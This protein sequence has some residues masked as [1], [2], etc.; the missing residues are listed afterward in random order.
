MGT[1][2]TLLVS[3]PTCR[4]RGIVLDANGDAQKCPRCGGLG[5]API[6]VKRVKFDYVLPSFLSSAANSVQ[7]QIL[8]LDTD[9]Y[10]EQVAWGLALS[11]PT[12]AAGSAIT[13][14]I[15]IVDQ[16]SG[17]QFSNAPVPLVDFASNFYS[18]SGALYP[19]GAMFPAPLVVPYIWKPGA[20]V[21]ATLTW[22]YSAL[23][24][25]TVQLAMKGYKLYQ[26]DGSALNSTNMPQLR[27]A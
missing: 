19:A 6:R 20:Q 12:L 26:P 18:F 11:V 21:Q 15:Q 27:A 17:F 4:G 3:C 13:G 2:P 9:S 5:R 24:Q 8:Q 10:F 14:Q 25:Y 22:P 7:S 23:S 16:S 1:F